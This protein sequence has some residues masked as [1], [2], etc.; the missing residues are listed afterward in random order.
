MLVTRV[1]SGQPPRAAADPSR[2][3]LPA[4]EGALTR[5][6][7]VVV[8]GGNAALCAALA[9]RDV[10]ADVLLVE[11][12]SKWMRGGNTRH[13]RNLRHAHLAADRFVSGVYPV[14]ELR[15]DIRATANDEGDPDLT[16][17]LAEQSAEIPGWAWD[18][19]V[20]WQSALRGTLSLSR[21]N[22]FF[23]G[24]GKSLVNAYHLTAAASGVKVLYEAAVTDFLFDGQR[25]QAIEI[26]E[27]ES[28]R[29]IE[30]RA[31]VAASG[32]FEANRD[33]LR[34]YWGD[35]ADNFTVR[36]SPL[37]DG[38]VLRRLLDHGAT[39]VG[40][41]SRFHAIAVDARAPREDAGILSRLDAIPFGIV[42]N[43]E[44]RRI[45][46]EGEDIWPK[47]YAIWGRL[48]AEQ[49]DQIAYVILD[50]K[51]MDEFM[52]TLY[53]PIEASTIGELGDSLGLA[54]T[55][56]VEAVET[57]N[58]HVAPGG[59]FSPTELD[60]CRTVGLAPPKSHWARPIDTPPFSA[61]PLRPGIT[62]TYHGL[63]VDASARVL[64]EGGPYANLFAAGEIMAGNIL[65]R[66]YLAGIGMTIGSVFGRLA[67]RE[68]ARRD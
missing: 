14:E 7:V 13:V 8:G 12:A 6:D 54:P 61:F 37:N 57:F 38:L 34:R 56:L 27:G 20:R 55:A 43:R 59:T 44:G 25:C 1:L 16:M 23:L 30:A 3:R 26:Q 5:F 19:G 53:P 11:R 49:P 68:A 65:T 47:R 22:R 64:G 18:H 9:A 42:V 35:A 17:Q 28:R 39:S 21:T 51:A 58:R 24:G 46:D 48:I 29:T 62:F 52:A 63:R 36:G 32:G 31:V 67:G 2:E 50:A 66:G 45:Y 41:P 40:D 60:D 15:S 10:G 33:W 4:H